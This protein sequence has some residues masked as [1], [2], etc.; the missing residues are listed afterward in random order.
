[1]RA[2]LAK[3]LRS[4]FRAEMARS[5]PQFHEDRAPC[6]IPGNIVYSFKQNDNLVYYIC[7][8]IGKYDSFTI[9]CAWS[10]DGNF[11]YDVMLATP[12]RFPQHF[13]KN[14][15]ANVSCLKFRLTALY[16]P[17]TDEW[18]TILES[19]PVAELMISLDSNPGLP[20][21]YKNTEEGLPKING[22]V[23]DVISKLL[24]YA[25]PYFSSVA[26]G[27]DCHGGQ[28]AEKGT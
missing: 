11:P 5:L 20:K 14:G 4:R 24:D 27:Q 19:I 17:Y 9:E 13:N 25:I 1:M 21:L 10:T 18:W 15:V 23:K 3:E 26:S 16:P 2:K 22:L 8:Y 7:L 28:R 12:G 6:R